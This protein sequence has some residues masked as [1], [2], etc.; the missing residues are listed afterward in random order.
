MHKIYKWLYKNQAKY[1]IIST[2]G[3]GSNA[4]VYEIL[5]LTS[6]KKY[7]C[8][9]YLYD[10]RKKIYKEAFILQQINTPNNILPKFY[11]TII[12][13]GDYWL[14]TDYIE[15]NE[16]YDKYFYDL[17]KKPIL[18]EITVKPLVLKMLNCI[19]ECNKNNIVHLD[20]KTENF[21]CSSDNKI[22]LIDFGSAEILNENNDI[23]YEL[24]K[25]AGTKSYCAPE[26]YKHRFHINSDI[27]SLGIC[28]YGLLT[29]ERLFLTNEI[30]KPSKH[31]KKF[32]IFSAELQDL[33]KSIFVVN[34]FERIYLQDFK[35]HKWLSDIKIEDI[36]K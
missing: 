17:S 32:N 1:K 9:Q 21:V 31:Y 30:I 18:N 10:T 8:K 12:K 7:T 11:K 25:S 22:S 2:L 20:I 35:N 16:L 36:K 3:Y 23:L 13:D 14:L 26:I 15:G 29:N 24:N 27:W 19:E 5:C 4:N 28:I 34:P 6:Q 33:L